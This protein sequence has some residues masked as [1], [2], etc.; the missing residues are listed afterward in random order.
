MNTYEEALAVAQDEVG[1][2]LIAATPETWRKALL[3]VEIGDAKTRFNCQITSPEGLTERVEATDELL[4]SLAAVVTVFRTAGRELW[5]R[6]IFE[7]FE[8]S[9]DDWRFR[10]DY[11]Y[12]DESA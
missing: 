10:V 2:C 6:M 4:N 7:A 1:R 11:L 12:R 5:V 8:A 3:R 9:Q